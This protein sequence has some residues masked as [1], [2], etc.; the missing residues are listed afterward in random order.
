M[1]GT[2]IHISICKDFT[3]EEV[4]NM[5]FNENVIVDKLTMVKLEDG[6]GFIDCCV[7]DG[8]D[9]CG[10]LPLASGVCVAQS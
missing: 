10:D 3:M 8:F 7:A 6:V 4:G 9:A 5:P 1:L 2:D